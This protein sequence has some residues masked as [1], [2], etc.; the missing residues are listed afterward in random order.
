MAWS[1]EAAAA[2]LV[3]GAAGGGTASQGLKGKESRVI[4]TG[5]AFQ[6]NEVFPHVTEWS[7]IYSVN[8]RPHP[9]APQF[10]L[11]RRRLDAVCFLCGLASLRSHRTWFNVGISTGYQSLTT[12]ESLLIFLYGQASHS[13]VK[14]RASQGTYYREFP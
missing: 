10:A 8:E 11:T 1:A 12:R 6:H 5:P 2:G 9:P 7:K 14:T 4:I 13:N 3:I